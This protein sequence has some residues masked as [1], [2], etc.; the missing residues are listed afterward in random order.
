MG[1][2]EPGG[3]VKSHLFYSKSLPAACIAS[4]ESDFR[5]FCTAPKMH[6]TCT[7]VV[8][9]QSQSSALHPPNRFHP[10]R[11]TLWAPYQSPTDLACAHPKGL[12]CV[13]SHQLYPTRLT[14]QAPYQSPTDLALRTLKGCCAHLRTNSIQPGSPCRLLTSRLQTSPYAP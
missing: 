9:Y 2:R 8:H 4:T 11:L 10:T 1:R 12:L 13:P 7:K 14:L 6:H 5:T 3:C